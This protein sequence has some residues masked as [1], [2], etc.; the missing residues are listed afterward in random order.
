[1]CLRTVARSGQVHIEDRRAATMA[2][3]V[4][5]QTPNESPPDPLD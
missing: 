5:M 2:M 3:V 1:M 4:S